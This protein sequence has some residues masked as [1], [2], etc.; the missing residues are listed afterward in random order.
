MEEHAYSMKDGYFWR[1]TISLALASFFVFA[2]M[3]ATQPLLP[4]FVKEFNVSVS[5]STLS[6]SLTIIGLIIGLIVLGFLS[7]RNGRTS[8]IKLS[9]AGAAIPFIIMPLS[10]SFLL[11][12][13]LRLMQGF[14]LAG[15]PAAALAYLME[16]IDK[17]SLPVATALYISSN[18]LGGMVGRVMTGYLSDHVSWENAF[19][20]LGAVGFIVLLAVLFMLPDSRFF[21]PSKAT[22]SEDMKG[23]FYHFKNPGL[24]FICGIGVVLQLSFTG[25][26][27][28]LPFY[29]EA[30][31]FTLSLEA[32]SYMFL[33]YGFGVIGSPIAGWLAG[34]FGL[35]VIRQ[36]GIIV[37]TL[38]ALMTLFP[39][40][41]II[42][43]GLCVTCLGF[44]TAHSLTASSVGM[45]VSH[46]KGSASSLYLVSYY[47][48]VSLGSS[49]IGPLWNGL[50]WQGLIITLGFIPVIYIIIMVLYKKNK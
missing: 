20:I 23:F 50:G 18:A 39:S 28:Y 49:A 21:T 19:Y 46:H 12:L 38:G 34:R 24:L 42:M 8:F 31:P 36:I 35:V 30:P 25:I 6:L 37:M 15:L 3:Y 5:V 41:W 47:I 22:F 33:A 26:W 32:I 4:L 16:E 27:T 44:F 40:L 7:D 29:M 43:I 1:I 2:G 48:G 9:L 13:I 17:S 11:L 45:E 14:A 10:H